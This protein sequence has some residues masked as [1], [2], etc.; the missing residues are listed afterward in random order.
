MSQSSENVF[1]KN[2][3]FFLLKRQTHNGLSDLP[4]YSEGQEQCWEQNST[5]WLSMYVSLGGL[6]FSGSC[7]SFPLQPSIPGM[8]IPTYKAENEEK[9]TLLFTFSFWHYA[10]FLIPIPLFYPKFTKPQQRDTLISLSNKQL[11]CTTPIAGQCWE[12]RTIFKSH[13]PHL[14]NE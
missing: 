10:S 4:S 9:A 5:F 14:R 2:Y 13:G 3:Y 1:G 12:G 8:N 11:F 7:Q 6:N